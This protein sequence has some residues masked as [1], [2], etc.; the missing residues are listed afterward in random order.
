MKVAGAGRAGI[1][2]GVEVRAQQCRQHIN[3][4]IPVLMLSFR[5]SA[6]LDGTVLSSPLQILDAN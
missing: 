1:Q 2:C 4:W 6:K 3:I 5:S